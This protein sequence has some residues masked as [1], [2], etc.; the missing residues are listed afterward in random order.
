MKLDLDRLGNIPVR[1]AARAT[2][3][4]IDRLQDLTPEQQ[5]AGIT[6]CFTLACEHYGI[7]PQDM[8][9]YSN[10]IMHHADGRRPEFQAVRQFMKGEW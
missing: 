5:M 7:N 3:A 1:E 6:A 4:V 2:M 9:T 8:F 10:N